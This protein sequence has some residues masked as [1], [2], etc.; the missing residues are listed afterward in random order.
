[1]DTTSNTNAITIKNPDGAKLRDYVLAIP[2][3]D[4]RFFITKVVEAIG[5]PVNRK[6]FYNWEYQKCRIPNTYKKII[7]KVAGTEIFDK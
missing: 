1:M 7:E 6:S 3:S 5:Y 2:S 4:R